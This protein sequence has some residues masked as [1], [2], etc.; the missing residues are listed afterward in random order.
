[1]VSLIALPSRIDKRQL[2]TALSNLRNGDFSARMPVGMTGVDGQIADEFNELVEINQRLVEELERISQ[3]VGK[4]GQIS[5]RASIGHV[6]GAWQ[7]TI[8]SV[9]SLVNDL[10][11]PTAEKARVVGAVAEGGPFPSVRPRMQ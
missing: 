6:S 7:E 8:S 9:H 11:H 1:M 4:Q 5:Q 2:A 10:V 3:G